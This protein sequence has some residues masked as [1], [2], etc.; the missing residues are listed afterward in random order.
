MAGKEN[1]IERFFLGKGSFGLSRFHVLLWVLISLII[2][3]ITR[4]TFLVT[5][6]NPLD[7][8]PLQL[9]DGLGKPAGDH[10]LDFH[11]RGR[12]VSMNEL[13]GKWTLVVFGAFGPGDVFEK[14]GHPQP[15]GRHVSHLLR[16]FG[17]MA[18][19]QGA[20][21][22]VIRMDH[23]PD[24]IERIVIDGNGTPSGGTPSFYDVYEHKYNK[25]PLPWDRYLL[26]AERFMR[27][28]RYYGNYY[29]QGRRWL[30]SEWLHRWNPSAPHNEGP[31]KEFTATDMPLY[32]ILDHDGNLKWLGYEDPERV[33][34]TLF[35]AMG[36][37]KEVPP[38]LMHVFHP[39][40]KAE[41]DANGYVDFTNWKSKDMPA[42]FKLKKPVAPKNRSITSSYTNPLVK[43]H[44][45]MYKKY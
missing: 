44:P 36:V 2:L 19:S 30:E 34:A 26:A 20:Q 5:A 14:P 21:L 37:D 45:D 16:Y 43:Y 1:K 24:V 23:N 27:H 13:H 15:D 3:D 41:H 7:V 17:Y 40:Y 38:Y 32:A 6:T 12:K 29:L 33:I 31:T 28:P 9:K 25:E 22:V 35:H 42:S 18:H 11:A 4:L 10:L 39:V 8:S